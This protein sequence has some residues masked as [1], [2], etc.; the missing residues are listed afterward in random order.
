[1]LKKLLNN[2]VFRNF[3]YLTVS[4]V[5]S[6]LI[7]LVTILK[8]TSI[9]NPND[10][11]LFTFLIAQGS[12]LLK[13]GD[14]GNRNIV[15]RTVAREPIQTND[16]LVNGGIVRSFAIIVLFL[17]YVVYN[18]FLGSLS[19]EHL[20]LIFVFTLI[21]CFASL[22]ELIFMGN[23]KM[24][25][26]SMIN[27]IYS[28]IWFS[29]IFFLPNK[30]IDIT[31][32]F[33]LYI[34]VTFLKAVLFLIFLKYHKLLIGRVQNFMVS[35]RQ[36]IKESWPYFVLILI[37]LPLTSLSNNF[38]DINSD[39]QQIGYFNLSQ[40]LIGPLS[41]IIT[42][43]L[44]AIFPNLSALWVKDKIKFNNYLSKGFRFFMLASMIFCFLFTL[45][46]KEVVILLFPVEYLPAVA[47]CQIQVWYLFLTSIDSLIGVILGAAN[48]EKLILRFGIVYFFICT[49][50]LYYGSKYGALG[51]S[52][53]YVIAFGAC[54]IYV[55]L[56]FKRTLG[57]ELKHN[58][59][60]W[61]MG[62]SLFLISYFLPYD[63]ALGYKLLLSTLI[64]MGIA[65]YLFKSYKS[66]QV[67]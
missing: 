25:P 34:A 62:I 30:A 51:L 28:V 29:I 47:V 20:A 5:I 4:T 48:K 35:T 15:I 44:T 19:N 32:I 10:Y 27:L 42:M 60:I 33:S 58:G 24:F 22:F 39:N 54:L 64:L 55:W 9:L 61:A 17:I 53:S 45:F 49:P 1:M 11:G 8:I 12:L 50:A 57:L 37:M 52:Y 63:M 14:L 40:R 56:T 21:S 66:I 36:L 13:I 18:H 38:L 2:I 59:F 7:A 16:L 41:L 65:T 23:Q 6:Q 43:M 67:K 3:S 26:S 46:A 31:I